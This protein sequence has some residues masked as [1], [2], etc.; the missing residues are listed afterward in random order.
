MDLCLLK[1]HTGGFTNSKIQVL[2]KQVTEAYVYLM[3][4]MTE[5]SLTVGVV[6]FS[7]K[8]VAAR[9]D[10]NYGGE[11]LV[12]PLVFHAL[13]RHWMQQD[14]SLKLEDAIRKARTFVETNLY[15][16][17][18]YPEFRNKFDPEFKDNP[19]PSSKEWHIGKVAEEYKSKTGSSLLNPQVILFDD[20]E[21]NISEANKSGVI[22]IQVDEDVGFSVKDWEE[23]MD[24]AWSQYLESLR[25]GASK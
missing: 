9:S 24:L 11:E 19:M 8:Q 12:R 13:R 6:T 21:R 4:I 2:S 7:D 17:A 20:G 10:S 3:D 1:I 16:K 22:G 15:V 25:K 14:R 18:A 23:A 5:K